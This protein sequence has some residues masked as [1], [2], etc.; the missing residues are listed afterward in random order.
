MNFLS[1]LRL[2]R[3]LALGF[4]LVLT[5]LVSV[6]VAAYAGLG[7][8]SED[9]QTIAGNSVPSLQVAADLKTRSLDLRRF[10]YNHLV[11]D[12]PG[13]ML[14]METEIAKVLR[15]LGFAE[16]D[17]EKP[18]EQFSGGW[19][20]RIALAKVLLGWEAKYDIDRMCADTWRWQSMNPLGFVPEDTADK[21]H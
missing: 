10:E 18:C 8:I 17:W 15:G 20:M 16:A 7:Q 12:E 2:G 4:G 6:A 9:L 21:R 13:K 5:L 3:R 11:S 1:N 19:Q 14:T